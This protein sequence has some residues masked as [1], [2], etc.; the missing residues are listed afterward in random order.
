MI[1]EFPKA[2]P[3]LSELYDAMEKAYSLHAE[4][5]KKLNLMQDY[6]DKLQEAFE[7]ELEF[8]I[9]HSIA[10]D[11][12]YLKASTKLVAVEHP[13]GLLLKHYTEVDND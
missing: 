4:Q 2:K 9:K 10:V 8:A 7:N 5:E 6:V 11:Y 3:E 12:K 13:D 1:I